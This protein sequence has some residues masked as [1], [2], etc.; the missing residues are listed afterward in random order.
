[1]MQT[2]NLADEVQ[3]LVWALVDNE[4]TDS[5]VGRLEELLLESAKARRL[6]VSCMQ[7]HADLLNL[8][9]RKQGPQFLAGRRSQVRFANTP[10]AAEWQDSSG[11]GALVF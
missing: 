11:N 2:V 6:Y 1:M 7:M 8:L 9:G 10:V 3:E 4:A 5:Q